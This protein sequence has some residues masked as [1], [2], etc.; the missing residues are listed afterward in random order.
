M[1]HQHGFKMNWAW[2]VN[3]ALKMTELT[4]KTFDQLSGIKGQLRREMQ[5]SVQTRVRALQSLSGK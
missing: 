4:R 3:S 5:S 2:T 1:H